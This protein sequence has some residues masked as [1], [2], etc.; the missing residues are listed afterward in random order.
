MTEPAQPEDPTQRTK[1]TRSLCRGPEG[2]DFSYEDARRQAAE[3]IDEADERYQSE[4]DRYGTE[5]YRGY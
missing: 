2:P 5:D 4:V 3:D 1:R